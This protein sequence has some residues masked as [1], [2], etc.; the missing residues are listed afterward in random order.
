MKYVVTCLYNILTDN[1]VHWDKNYYEVYKQMTELCHLSCKKFIQEYKIVHI[2]EDVDDMYDANRR[3]FNHIYD[4]WKSE[5]CDILFLESDVLVWKPF[6]LEPH[7]DFHTFG[8]SESVRYYPHTMSNEVWQVGFYGITQSRQY[9]EHAR[10][11]YNV[12][13][14]STC[15]CDLQ[16]T[17]V[18]RDIDSGWY[19]TNRDN[20]SIMC[21][22]NGSADPQF[23]LELMEMHAKQLGIIK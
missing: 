8:Y 12:M 3:I 22:Y 13:N 15:V 14:R 4:L 5:P 7:T 10:A 16:I 17:E 18:S 20:Q 11:L 1:Y 19:N 23:R 6:T 9:I 2:E 21:H